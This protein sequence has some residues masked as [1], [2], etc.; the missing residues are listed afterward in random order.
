MP[1]LVAE[2]TRCS[3]EGELVWAEWSWSGTQTD[4]ARFER[5]GVAI[6]ALRDGR[7]QWVRT[8]MQ[9]ITSEPAGAVDAAMREMGRNLPGR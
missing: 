9:P 4:G 2:L 3:V 1:N 5:T 6:H 8:Y 7:V